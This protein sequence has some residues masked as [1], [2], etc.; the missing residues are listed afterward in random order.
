[1]HLTEAR[2]DALR[3][4]IDSFG[5]KL[6]R[7]IIEGVK[8]DSSKLKDVY[9]FFKTLTKEVYPQHEGFAPSS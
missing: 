3:E 7:N 8:I 6:K 5:P 1:M 9:E 4:L 2:R